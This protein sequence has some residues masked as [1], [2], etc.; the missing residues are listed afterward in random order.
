[1]NL[2]EKQPVF[3]SIEPDQFF[4]FY[5]HE[6]AKEMLWKWFTATVTDGFSELAPLEKENIITLYE[7]LN[8][9]LDSLHAAEAAKAKNNG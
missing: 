2:S 4:D 8:S 6:G 9:L 1:M 3:K 5:S 7:R